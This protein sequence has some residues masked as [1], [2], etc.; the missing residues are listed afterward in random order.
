M[1]VST[2]HRGKGKTG[3]NESSR[4]SLKQVKQDLGNMPLAMNAETFF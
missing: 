1:T 2:E 4:L 3:E